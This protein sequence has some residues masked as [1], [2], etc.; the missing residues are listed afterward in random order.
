[1]LRVACTFSRHELRGQL[2][3]V[4]MLLFASVVEITSCVDA[5]TIIFEMGVNGAHGGI[6]RLKLNILP[7]FTP[8]SR[9]IVKYAMQRMKSIQSLS[10]SS[11]VT[12][13]F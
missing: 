2:N 1:M 12:L 4:V 11:F 3:R 5:K 8:I 9:I 10:S 7:L 6:F 13:V